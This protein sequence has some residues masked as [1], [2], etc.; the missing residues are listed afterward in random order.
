M[1]L[2]RKPHFQSG[3]DWGSC[4]LPCSVSSP[5]R[6]IPVSSVELRVVAVSQIWTDGCCRLDLEI[7][8]VVSPLNHDS[9]QS[10]KSCDPH[11]QG[12]HLTGIHEIGNRVQFKVGCGRGNSKGSMMGKC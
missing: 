7:D 5:I 10:A 1:N 8:I 6:L 11:F 12:F 4:I 3:W 9:D 2:I